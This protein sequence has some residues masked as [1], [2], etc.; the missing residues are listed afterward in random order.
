VEQAVVARLFLVEQFQAPFNGQTCQAHWL[1]PVELIEFFFALNYAPL[2][3]VSGCRFYIAMR[4]YLA[5]DAHGIAGTES[6]GCGVRTG[7]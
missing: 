7:A 2:C 3:I 1:D 4:V 6:Q 5:H